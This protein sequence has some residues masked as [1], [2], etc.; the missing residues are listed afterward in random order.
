MF[1]GAIN[2]QM[3]AVLDQLAKG[4]AG[5]DV[6][7]ACSGN[8][9]VER[10]LARHG[11]GAI[12]S[13]DVSIYSCALGWRLAGQVLDYQIRLDRWAWL[14]PYLD[15]GLGTIATLLLLTTVAQHDREGAYHKRMLDAYRRGFGDLHAKTRKRVSKALKGLRVDS[16]YAGDLRDFVAQAPKAGTVCLSFPPTYRRGCEQ[17]YRRMES[18]F[19][20]PRPRY[21]MFG[22]DDFPTFLQGVRAFDQWVTSTDRRVEDA[23]ANLVAEVQTS[24]RSHPVF[25]YSNATGVHRLS[26]P[27][28]RT[29]RLPWRPCVG[30]VQAPLRIVRTDNATLEAMRSLYL[31]RNI[32][33]SAAMRCYAVLAGDGALIGALAFSLP[34]PRGLPES[35][36]QMYLLADF[37]VRPSPHKRLSKLIIACALCREIQTDLEQFACRRIASI[38]T[39]AFT[40]RPVTMKY[41]GVFDLYNRAPGRLNY[42][43]AAGKWN[44]S[45][46]LAWWTR[47]HSAK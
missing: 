19:A 8:F 36:C 17:A 16:F 42:T 41:R 34:R 26:R 27:V 35:V 28:V 45:E 39:T 33:T 18:I 20:W 11:V 22:P 10:V 47:L 13:N 38:G 1:V 30:Q 31:G 25:M 7:V 46:A 15:G 2:Q 29:A 23:E 40:D 43:G 5:R 37:A 6:Y 12:H 3:R 4:W 24:R 44:L 9:T 14:K 32:V 21:E